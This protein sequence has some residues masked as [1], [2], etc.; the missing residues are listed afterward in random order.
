ML[1]EI[2]KISLKQGIFN[3]NDKKNQIDKNVTILNIDISNDKIN[4][5]ILVSH[6]GNA[7]NAYFKNLYKLKLNDEV[8]LYYNDRKLIYK[9]NKIYS[10]PKNDV[11]SINKKHKNKLILITC[12]N[13]KEYLILES[14]N[15]ESRNKK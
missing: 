3:I 5:L 14:T 9:V 10:N 12:L 2:P 4:S 11:F 13:R 7:S 6:S 1:L 8:I 15:L